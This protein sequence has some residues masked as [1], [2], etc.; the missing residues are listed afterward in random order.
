MNIAVYCSS[1]P[2]LGQRYIDVARALGQWMGQH[3]HTLV[4]GGV[5]AGLMHVMA[6]AV[7]EN[8]GEAVGVITENFKPMADRLVDRLITT[9]DLSE[10]KSRM[11]ALSDFHVVLP[12]GIGTI[13]EWMAALSQH[14]VDKR[15]GVGIMV[16][17]IDGMYDH[18]INQLH[19]LANTRFA[20]DKHIEAMMEVTD[21]EQMLN[22]LDELFTL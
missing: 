17:N 21:T 22:K 5:N 14:V 18:I 10:R 15:E 20:G 11:Y 3:G 12:G 1:R 6:K 2:H 9:A 7:K 13:D 8:G 16:V 19:A 4:Y